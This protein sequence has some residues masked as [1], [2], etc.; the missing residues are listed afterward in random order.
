[1]NKDESSEESTQRE[2]VEES[3]EPT[4]LDAA[5]AAL[6]RMRQAATSR[7]DRRVRSAAVH[8]NQK[9]AAR[10]AGIPRSAIGAARDPQGL[11]GILERL[12]AERGWSSPV[13][14][15]SVMVQWNN[16]VGPEIA[17]HC[18][19]E[20]FEGTVLQ[21]RCD[22]TSWA[23]QLRLLSSSLLARFDADLGAGVVTKIQVLAPTAPNWRKGGRTVTG[24]GPRDT[25]G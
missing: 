12:V 3:E 10:Q 9:K 16:L 5:Q 2:A 18:Q 14:V 8:R 19:P 7:G 17:A 11:G 20:S 22:S 24:R 25:Y 13:A 1:M 6:N 23:T 15:G 21:V 4:D